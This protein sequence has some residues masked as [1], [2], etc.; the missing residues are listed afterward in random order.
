LEII[1]TPWLIQRQKNPFNTISEE[2]KE[3]EDKN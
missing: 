2:E 3:E 1:L